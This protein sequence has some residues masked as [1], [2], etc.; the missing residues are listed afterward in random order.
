MP[1]PN[2]SF[3]GV[4]AFTMLHH[5]PTVELQDRL[6]SEAHRVLSPGGIF[7]GFDGVGSL[8]FRLLHLSDTYMPVNPETLGNR[9]KAAGFKDVAVE[10]RH[11]R[12][13]FQATRP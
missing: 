6:F 11:G 13:R 7:V 8:F 3:S 9:L 5:V 10:R 12:F 2:G 1:F 4:V